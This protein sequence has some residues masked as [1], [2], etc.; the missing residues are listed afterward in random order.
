V[1]DARRR[2]DDVGQCGWK[3][4]KVYRFAWDIRDPGPSVPYATNSPVTNAGGAGTGSWPVS[5]AGSRPV[6][7]V[8]LGW[9]AL[10][11]CP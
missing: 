5:V 7:S 8:W 6:M 3:V 1:S 4:P 9:A 2:A 10:F 11:A